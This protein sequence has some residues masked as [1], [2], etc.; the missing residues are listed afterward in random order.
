[1][2]KNNQQQTLHQQIA[3]FDALVEWFESDDFV[4]EESID[5]YKKAQELAK[6]IEAALDVVENEITIINKS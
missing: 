6:E 5:Q 3:E 2:T 1:M 4:L